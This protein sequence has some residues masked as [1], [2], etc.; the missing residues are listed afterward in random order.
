[1]LG[2]QSVPR[3]D[4]DKKMPEVV[5]RIGGVK[6]VYVDRSIRIAE[7][8][9]LR[10]REERKRQEEKE[11][12]AKTAMDVATAVDEKAEGDTEEVSAAN[13][14]PEASQSTDMIE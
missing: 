7:I 4:L 2:A 9:R 10:A 3:L 12:N 6:V 11:K 8:E 5:E 1:M 14:I 13:N